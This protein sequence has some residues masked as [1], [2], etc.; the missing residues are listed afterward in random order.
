MLLHPN[1]EIK[2]RLR[3]LL[4]RLKRQQTGLHHIKRALGLSKS[5]DDCL[6]RDPKPHGMQ[7]THRP[8]PAFLEEQGNPQ[9]Y[10]E[11]LLKQSHR[12]A[13][14]QYL[15]KCR[16]YPESENSWE[17]EIPLR[18]DCPY[19]VGAFERHGRG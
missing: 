9:F 17:Y 14:Y 8:P 16:G 15:V 1:Q 11:R 12:H 3:A 13:Q 18:Q 7:P 6:P 2:L 10:V 5:R 19:A 4:T